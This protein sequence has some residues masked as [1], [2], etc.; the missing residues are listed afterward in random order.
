MNIDTILQSLVQANLISGK[1]VR[2][3]VPRK[4]PATFCIIRTKKDNRIKN[5]MARY[6]KGGIKVFALADK[7]DMVVFMTPDS[8]KLDEVCTFVLDEIK[9]EV[10]A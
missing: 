2:N 10:W 6:Q 4:A 3:S 8:D 1:E 7:M 5:A 9:E